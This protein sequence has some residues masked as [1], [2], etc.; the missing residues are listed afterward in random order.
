VD[1]RARGV[2][3]KS[4][5]S[6]TTTACGRTVVRRVVVGWTRLRRDG[7]GSGAA[8]HKLVRD[9]SESAPLFSTTSLRVSVASDHP[10]NTCSTA[11]SIACTSRCGALRSRSAASRSRALHCICNC[12]RLASCA[13]A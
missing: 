1:E 2:V 5:G 13:Y 9:S 7:V 10:F 3:C 4:S 11:N 6:C 8:C 12:P